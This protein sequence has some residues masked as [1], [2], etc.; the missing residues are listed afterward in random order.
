MRKEN[1]DLTSEI[2]HLKNRLT[3]ETKEAE[4]VHDELESLTTD[5]HIINAK[6]FE[7]SQKG[8]LAKDRLKASLN[9]LLALDPRKSTFVSDEMNLINK[10]K[11]DKE[12]FFKNLKSLDL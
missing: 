7:F 1:N 2:F 6:K 8:F 3:S 10:N 4:V 12:N 9:N 5:I 11:F